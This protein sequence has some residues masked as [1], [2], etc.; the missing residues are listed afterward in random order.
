M[1][2]L[3]HKLMLERFKQLHY[4]DEEYDEIEGLENVDDDDDITT[5]ETIIQET[6]EYKSKFE[7]L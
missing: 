6:T 7:E 5:E 3:E 1:Y 4:F 2:N